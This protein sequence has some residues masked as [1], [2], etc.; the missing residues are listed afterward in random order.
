[1]GHVC[2]RVIIPLTP[3]P[4]AARSASRPPPPKRKQ[5]QGEVSEAWHVMEGATNERAAR[6]TASLNTHIQQLSAQLEG[7]VNEALQVNTQLQTLPACLP[8]WDTTT[9]RGAP[10]PHPHPSS[11]NAPLPCICHSVLFL[12][13]TQQQELTYIS[14][15][16]PRFPLPRP[17]S[18]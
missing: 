17:S 7:A 12:H 15:W 8:A 6:L 11:S 2:V 3:P 1:V 13:H 10:K 5:I 18:Q 9:G 14:S 16:R 4:S